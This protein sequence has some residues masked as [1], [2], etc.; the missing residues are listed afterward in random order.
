MWNILNL[1]KIKKKRYVIYFEKYDEASFRYE[2]YAQIF[3]LANPTAD[4]Y[5][6]FPDREYSMHL[7][8]QELTS[9]KYE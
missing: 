2:T 9:S 6:F 4:V 5:F 1:V 3:W 8:K 7:T